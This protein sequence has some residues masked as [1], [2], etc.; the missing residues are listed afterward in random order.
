[1]L[2]DQGFSYI[3]SKVDLLVVDILVAD[4]LQFIF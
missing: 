2:K 3:I 4:I 1:M